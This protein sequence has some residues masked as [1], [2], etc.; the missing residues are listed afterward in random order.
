MLEGG[1]V[2][3]GKGEV[4]TQEGKAVCGNYSKDG[5]FIL[6]IYFICCLEGGDG[7]TDVYICA[8]IK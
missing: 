1:L 8:V 3:A 2:V 7:F 4:R 6:Y 5:C